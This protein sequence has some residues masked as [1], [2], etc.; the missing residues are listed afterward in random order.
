MKASPFHCLLFHTRTFQ[1]EDDWPILWKNGRKLQ[2][3][4]G[5]SVVQHGFGIPVSKIPPLSSVPIRISQSSSPFLREE[6][7]NLLNKR[8]LERVQNP[9][10]PS[11]YSRIFL[12]P[13]KNG[14]LRL[15][16]DL[17]LLNRYIKKQSFKMETVKSV[18]QAMRLNDW[19]VS[20]DQTDAYL[21][22][23]NVPKSVD[24]FKTDGHYSS[25]STPTCHISLS[26]PGRLADKKSDSQPFD[27]SDKILH[28]NYSK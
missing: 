18:R 24:I 27:Y 21:H 23:Q 16:I 26:I 15:F 6:I 9:G 20:I 10:T 7:E 14:K 8:A 4:N 3:T 5:S 19:A 12:V 11:F 17:S 1:W 25:V 28:S 2:T 13:K 22:V